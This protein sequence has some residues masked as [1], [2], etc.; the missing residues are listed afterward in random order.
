MCDD[1]KDLKNPSR[2]SFIRNVGAGVVGGALLPETLAGEREKEPRPK[3]PHAG[4][5]LLELTVNGTHHSLMI[6]PETTLV[7]V[8]RDLLGLTGTKIACNQGQCGTCTVLLNGKAVYS[9]HTL[10]LDANGADVTTIEGLMKGEELH[11]IQAAF[12][13][14]DGLQ[15]G[16]CTP[17]QV[18]TAAG[19]LKQHPDPTAEQ[20]RVGMSGTLCR[21]AAYP[22]IEKSVQKAAAHMKRNGETS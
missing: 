7:Q 3:R 10:A 1:R 9:C 12:L 13:E 2:R 17:G 5:V 19:L 21:C 16:F 18:M 20:I 8:I 14:E 22:N 15:C 11:P 6:Q 4:E